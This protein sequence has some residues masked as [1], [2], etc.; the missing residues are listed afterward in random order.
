MLLRR[1]L[2]LSQRQAA[3]RAGIP[4]GSWQGLEDD[5]RQSRDLVTKIQRIARAYNVDRDWLMW[6]G[7]L[8]SPEDDTPPAG[9]PAGFAGRRPA[10][11]VKLL[12]A[13]PVAGRSTNLA[14]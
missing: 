9:D 4:F 5:H 2:G 3:E 7:E 12:T 8:M 6:G 11:G 14:A 13:W 1:E 10:T